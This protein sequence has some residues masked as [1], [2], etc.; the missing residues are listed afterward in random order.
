M[1]QKPYHLWHSAACTILLSFNARLLAGP[2]SY[3]M[4]SIPQSEVASL[5]HGIM[6][7]CHEALNGLH[8]LVTACNVVRT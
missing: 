2:T 7:F 1:A 5:Q 3:R 8:P 4:H 6:C